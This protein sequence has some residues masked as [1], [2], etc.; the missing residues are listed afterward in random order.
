MVA[1][2]VIANMAVAAGQRTTS[3]FTDLLQ[4]GIRYDR[5]KLNSIPFSYVFWDTRSPP[6]DQYTMPDQSIKLS[7][8]TTLL[9]KIEAAYAQ[10]GI[11]EIDLSGQD[12]YMVVSTDKM[13]DVYAQ[14]IETMPIGSLSDDLRELAKL[15]QSSDPFPTAVDI[16][17]LGNVLRAVAEVLNR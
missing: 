16:E 9:Q 17:R 1:Q 11:L 15:A 4:F 10:R 8:L 2:L 6:L 7:V 5:G 14:P 12:F 3:R 13:F